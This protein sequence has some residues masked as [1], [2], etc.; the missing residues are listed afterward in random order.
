M[1]CTE[2]TWLSNEEYLRK[3]NRTAERLRIPLSGSLDLTHRCNLRCIHCY[4]GDRSDLK[5]YKEMNTE[6]ILSILDQI[7]EAGCLYLLITG[8]EPLL[9]EDFR[10]IYSHAKTNGLLVTV[11]TNGTLITDKIIRLFNDL[12]PHIVEISLYGATASTYEKI[13]KVTGSYERCLHGVRQLLKH[14]INVRLKTIL[15]TVNKHEF[16][17]I[18]NIAQD[19]GV[20]FR[21]DAAVFPCLDGNMSPL[22]LRVPPEDAIR[23]EFSLKDRFESWKKYLVMTKGQILADDLYN[24][25]AGITSFHIDPYGTLKPCLMVN[26]ITYNLKNGSFFIGWH[27]VLST[28]R[29]KKIGSLSGCNNCEKRPLCGF[30]PAFFE[31]ENGLEYLRSEYLCAMGNQRFQLIYNNNTTNTIKET[32]H[33]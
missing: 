32:V 27:D 25:G 24:C 29:D 18:E 14:N 2:K 5:P 1:Q 33:G 17:N 22:S 4:L 11:F 30:C 28:I 15:M 13:T 7:T 3:F 16:F 26:N 6:Q 20:R 10:E 31:L 21:F 9:R 23:L 12:P 8:G 19:F